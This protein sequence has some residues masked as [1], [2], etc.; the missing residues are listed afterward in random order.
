MLCARSKHER[1]LSLRRKPAG[2]RVQQHV[3]DFFANG[4][5]ARFAGDHDHRPGFAQRPRQLFQLSAFAAAVQ[6]FDGDEP[7]ALRMSRHSRIIAKQE[8]RTTRSET[9]KCPISCTC[10]VR[11]PRPTCSSVTCY[12][13][14]IETEC[15]YRQP[16]PHCTP[17]W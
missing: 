4:S 10:G 1:Q 5:S 9:T 11:L 16:P 12:W 14:A 15:S 2:G 3:A 6:A 17:G 13:R 7:A 8:D